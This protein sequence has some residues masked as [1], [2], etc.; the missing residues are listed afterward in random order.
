MTQYFI[1]NLS[2]LG[3]RW[4]VDRTTSTHV[5]GWQQIPTGP[6]CLRLHSNVNPFKP[7]RNFNIIVRSGTDRERGEKKRARKRARKGDINLDLW[8][9]RSAH[10]RKR[11][12]RLVIDSFDHCAA[13]D[14]FSSTRYVSKDCFPSHR[15]RF[16]IPVGHIRMSLR[17]V[18]VRDPVFSSQWNLLRDARRIDFWLWFTRG[19]LA[20]CESTA[21]GTATNPLSNTRVSVSRELKPVANRKRTSVLVEPRRDKIKEMC[22]ITLKLINFT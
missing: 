18:E 19:K 5:N 11:S 13:N 8:P 2:N 17:E 12:P 20:A 10:R 15:S 4:R 1:W 16:L 14:R 22:K 9:D 3:T 21:R 6:C 7:A